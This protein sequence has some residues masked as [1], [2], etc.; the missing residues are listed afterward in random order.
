MPQNPVYELLSVFFRGGRPAV[1]EVAKDG[2]RQAAGDLIQA[3]GLTVSGRC[4]IS[5]PGSQSSVDDPSRP[6]PGCD[7]SSKQP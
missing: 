1:S 2:L 3:F 6:G 7:G 4:G 5:Q